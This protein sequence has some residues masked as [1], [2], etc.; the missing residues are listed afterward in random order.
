MSQFTPHLRATRNTAQEQLA[1]LLGISRQ[2]ATKREAEKSY[3]EMD[4]LIKICRLFGCTLDDFVTGDPT[5]RPSEDL[6]DQEIDAPSLSEK[7]RIR[8]RH[9]NHRLQPPPARR[10]AQT[11][12]VFGFA[13]I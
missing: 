3:P 12:D 1:M 9:C 2:S 13:Q 10:N 5:Q 4:K 8:L 7:E 6:S 11:R